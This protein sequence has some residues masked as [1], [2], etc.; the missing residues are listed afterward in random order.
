MGIYSREH[1]L[2]SQRLRSAAA[3]VDYFDSRISLAAFLKANPDPLPGEPCWS[4]TFPIREG[5]PAERKARADEIA[6][7]PGVVTEWR[8]GY[9]MGRLHGLEI[10]FDPPIF[11]ADVGSDDAAGSA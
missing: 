6:G 11:L 1:D 4:E 9:Y 8:N 3:R 10:H 2:P 7:G 5:S